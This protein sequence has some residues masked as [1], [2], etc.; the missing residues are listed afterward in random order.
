MLNIWYLLYWDLPHRII[1]LPKLSWVIHRS[2]LYI[3]LKHV[4]IRWMTQLTGY[5]E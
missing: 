1:D 2:I 3:N 5:Y 4:R